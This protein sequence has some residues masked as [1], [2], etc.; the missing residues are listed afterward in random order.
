[1][2]GKQALTAIL[3]S[4][5]PQFFQ[6][7]VEVFGGGGALLF[8]KDPDSHHEIY[9]DKNHLLCN[10]F[11][12]VREF[13]EPLIAALEF[14]LNSREDFRYNRE[15][16]R[17]AFEIPDVKMAAK[18]YQNVLQS[19]AAGVTSFGG[20]PRSMWSRFPAILAASARLQ[21]VVIE[22][23]DFEPLFLQHDAT[24]T[25]FYCDPPYFETEDYYENVGFTKDDH[26]RLFELISQA[27]G[28]ILL[29][30]N[31]CDEIMELYAKP[32]FMILA[33]TRLNNIAQRYEGGKQYGE[34]IIG[35]YDLFAKINSSRQMTLWGEAES[36]IDER[37]VIFN[38]I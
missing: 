34:L 33:A 32:G 4:L 21:N 2:G 6:K 38:G 22:N 19:Y 17:Q 9:N 27:T 1:M 28:K 23:K 8:H 10:F 3:V 12:C 30:Y 16:L 20:A 25:L 5:F 24:D 36:E 26:F 11:R 7:Y 14:T 18:Y 29:G 13:P 31:H 37:N 35:N 15:I